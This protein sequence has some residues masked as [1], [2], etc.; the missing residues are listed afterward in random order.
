MAEA[1]ILLALGGDIQWI[2]TY[3]YNSLARALS[4]IPSICEKVT[5][6]STGAIGP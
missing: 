4:D 6:A 5:V 3:L 1:H 2:G